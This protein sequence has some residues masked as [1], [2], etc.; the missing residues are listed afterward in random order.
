MQKLFICCRLNKVYKNDWMKET[1][2]F[3]SEGGCISLAEWE[4][5][6][7]LTNATVYI[8]IADNFLISL[9]ENWFSDNEV[10][11]SER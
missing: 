11:F 4:T 3:C 9:R 2:H 6:I 5:I 7:T 10:I 1:I 8:E